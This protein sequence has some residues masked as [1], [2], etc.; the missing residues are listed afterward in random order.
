MYFMWLF[1]VKYKSM[2]KKCWKVEISGDDYEVVSLPLKKDLATLDAITR[3]LPPGAY[4][5]FRTYDHDKAL[6]IGSHL[7]RLEETARF[8]GK[9]ISL[10][11]NLLRE[12]IRQVMG[13]YPANQ[14]V[15]IRVVLDL[16]EH[17]GVIYLMAEDLKT[18]V[19]EAYE[20][21]V[22]LVTCDMHRRNPKAKLTEFIHEA[23][24]VRQDLDTGI[25]D[26]LMVDE[27]GH[28]LEGLT[29]NFFAVRDG[30][31]WTNE[32][33][34][35]SGIT[36]S[37]VLDEAKR[38]KLIVYLDGIHISEIS[39]LDEAFITSSS[40]AIL[41]VIQI[42]DQEIGDGKPGEITRR[43]MECLENR[44]RMEIKPI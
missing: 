14:E 13:G 36:R 35:L 7:D 32:K 11:Q 42:D 40:R 12:S 9:P 26:A 28:I 15:R 44:I 3:Y 27:T 31:L 38:I 19:A 24:R 18:P 29:S 16:E 21:G 17:P 8:A 6:R 22:R 10:N 20:H 37:L 33:D 43:L 5:T 23:D 4:T 25:E 2:M 41:P 30:H 39:S 1:Q 34:V